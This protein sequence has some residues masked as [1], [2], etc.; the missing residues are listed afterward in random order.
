MRE[1]KQ[2][3]QKLGQSSVVA[4]ILLRTNSDWLYHS[5]S[6]VRY[7]NILV[8]RVY[9]THFMLGV[10]RSIIMTLVECTCLMIA[11][12]EPR[13]SV[14]EIY[15]GKHAPITY[16]HPSTSAGSELMLH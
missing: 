15:N 5:S 6:A 13:M 2:C 11:C 7:H 3:A 12:S 10:V 14:F 1:D 8:A 4:P 9:S 16:S